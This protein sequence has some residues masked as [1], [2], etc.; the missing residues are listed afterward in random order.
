VVSRADALGAGQ[1]G[2]R[3]CRQ[4][5]A[6]NCAKRDYDSRFFGHRYNAVVGLDCNDSTYRARTIGDEADDV[7]IGHHHQPLL[8]VVGARPSLRG[9]GNLD[10]QRCTVEFVEWKEPRP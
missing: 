5:G 10:D 4:P 9:A 8:G 7:T 2:Q 6:F 1:T 3:E